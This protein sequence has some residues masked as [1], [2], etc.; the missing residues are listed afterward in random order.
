MAFCAGVDRLAAK[1]CYLTF[2]KHGMVHQNTPSS[3]Q[4]WLA[5][6]IFCI[7]TS[8]NT[9]LIILSGYLVRLHNDTVHPTILQ[10][11]GG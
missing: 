11:G 3:M 2:V 6:C 10:G 9:K 8:L 1:F 7:N 5:I 4:N